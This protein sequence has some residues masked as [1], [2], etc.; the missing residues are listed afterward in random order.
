MVHS[1]VA[2]SGKM[3]KMAIWIK[4]EGI[5]KLSEGDIKIEDQKLREREMLAVWI[6]KYG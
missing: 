6:N 1:T 3:D 2:H 5:I 4:L